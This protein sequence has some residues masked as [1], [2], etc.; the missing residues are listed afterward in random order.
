MPFGK[1]RIR[2]LK[3]RDPKSRPLTSMGFPAYSCSLVDPH[4]LGDR[5]PLHGPKAIRF[6]VALRGIDT[7]IGFFVLQPDQ[8][9]GSAPQDAR[10]TQRHHSP[11]LLESQTPGHETPVS[12]VITGNTR[13]ISATPE[14]LS[15][16]SFPVANPATHASPPN[17]LPS[18]DGLRS[19][20][21][22][23]SDFGSARKHHRQRPHCRR[24][25]H[26]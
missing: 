5:S 7:G 11:R 12:L 20:A 3:D 6:S 22:L 8:P 26:Q 16:R 13:R 18:S 14:T 2:H 15:T 4:N 17:P 9:F 19:S 10:P 24:R 1:R 25:L 21:F 23:Q